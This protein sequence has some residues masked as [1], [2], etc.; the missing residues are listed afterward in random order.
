MD[1]RALISDFSKRR[2][3]ELMTKIRDHDTIPSS[4]LK[5]EFM[6]SNKAVTNK[7]A[8][9][10]K[11]SSTSL[12]SPLTLQLGINTAK[13]SATK[14]KDS[15]LKNKH[16]TRSSST[17]S[18]K[19]V[20]SPLQSPI[21]QSTSS[22]AL[23]DS[24]MSLDSIVFK[25]ALQSLPENWETQNTDEKLTSM[26]NFFLTSNHLM[27]E[28]LNLIDKRLDSLQLNV[29]SNTASISELREELNTHKSKTAADSKL[30][31]DELSKLKTQAMLH[32]DS[33]SSTRTSSSS[34]LVI[35]G[36]PD[37]VAASLSPL[38]ITETVFNTLKQMP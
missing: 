9:T 27:T 30:F 24:N 16:L 17:S 23:T 28:K 18:S 38:D 1:I 33:S 32:P 8:N 31:I 15:R 14:G 4:R 25:A 12:K 22:I 21:T 6:T 13:T 20:T 36:I 11:T 35:S 10:Q 19:S 7:Q 34:E 2:Q 26:M 29:S 5:Y 3:F 37:V